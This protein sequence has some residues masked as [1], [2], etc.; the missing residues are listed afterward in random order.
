MA[1]PDLTGLNIED[2]Y[3]RLVHTDGADYFDGTGSLLDLGQNPR[4]VVEQVKNVSGIFLPKGTPV[5]A[6]GS[7]TSGNLVGI[8][9]ADAGDPTKMPATYVLNIDLDDEEEGEAIAVGYIQGVDTRGLIE[10]EVVYVAVG[11]GWTQ[12]KPTGS[13]LI[14]NLG[15]VTKVGQNGSG[16]VLGAGRSNDLPNIQ[17]GYTWVGNSNGVPTAVPTSSLIIDPFPYTGSAVISGSFQTIGPIS[18]S[19][20]HIS[21]PGKPR[22]QGTTGFRLVGIL[23]GSGE[24]VQYLDMGSSILQYRTNGSAQFQIRSQNGGADRVY[25]NFNHADTPL[26]NVSIGTDQTYGSFIIARSSNFSSNR[27]FVITGSDGSVGI[28][29][30]FPS[31]KLHIVGGNNLPNNY[32]LKVQ[33]SSSNNIL[34]VENGGSTTISG[35]LI[36][37]GSF[38]ALLPTSSNDTY[39]LTYNTASYQLEAREVAT[40]INPKV[41]YYDVTASISS[42]T[43]ITLPN[44]LSYI[45]S[46]IY[47]Y[48]EVF[49]NGL[50]LRYN[51]DF[52]PTS[53]TT[54]Q[55]QI[56]FPSGSELTFKSLKA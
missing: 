36:L 26:T 42:G 38:K 40:L 33:N 9:A 5:H 4:T 50:R 47:E 34:T 3:P 17:S 2:T 56:A 29:T 25:L 35:S 20:L 23:G 49:F 30:D 15:V 1:L 16:V 13:A 10:G 51:R 43:S 46:S 45:S 55:T 31:A 28:N 53:I 8:I 6:T 12:T 41:E 32:V 14:Q 39:F 21:G 44:G 27:D 52:I 48:L 22:I 11:G 7:G 19:S 37:T 54:I 24:D 18:G